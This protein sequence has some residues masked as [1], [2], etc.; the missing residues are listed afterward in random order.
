MEAWIKWRTFCRWHFVMHFLALTHWPLGDH[1]WGCDFRIVIFKPILEID[2]LNTCSE[3]DLSWMPQNPTGDGSTLAQVMAWC[4]KATRYYLGKCWTRFTMPN[5]IIRSQWVKMFG[6]QS[7]FHRMVKILLKVLPK[8]LTEK[9]LSIVSSKKSLVLSCSKPLS[10]P[11][12]TRS[13]DA[14]QATMS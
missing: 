11:M 10:E 13:F 8:G 6:F 1:V 3:I 2:I 9:K 14:I 5:S 12:L 7:K 4:C